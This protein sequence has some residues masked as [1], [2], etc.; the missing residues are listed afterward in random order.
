[1][2]RQMDSQTLSAY[3]AA[4][5]VFATEWHAQPAPSDL[6]ELVK[7][8]FKPGRTADIGAGSGRDVAW[9]VANGFPAVGY[10]PSRGLL[11]E[12]R[13]RY[14]G[15]TFHDAALPELAGIPDSTFDNVLC[16]TVIMHLARDQIATSVHRL[17][18]ILSPGGILY[19]SWRVTK[20]ADQRDAHGRLYTAYDADLVRLALRAALVL[21][22]EEVVSA[23]SAKTI[24]R[25][26]ARK[27]EETQR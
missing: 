19:L 10:E 13:A 12:A 25:I 23:S 8:F 2:A 14:P 27:D 26:V 22:D 18:A 4:A 15:L 17:L 21:L 24:H 20:N 5:K 1:M 11:N 3:D 16:E 7:R 6:Q 9:L